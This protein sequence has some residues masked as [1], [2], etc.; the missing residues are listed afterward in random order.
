MADLLEQGVAWLQDQRTKHATR[1][2]TYVR[3]EQSVELAATIGRTIFRLT[4]DCGA[5]V[6]DVTRD[7]LV[8]A[9]D[10]ALGGQPITPQRGDRVREVDAG[11][12]QTFE[13]EVLSPGGE[14]E[15]RWSDPYRRTLR[16]H[17]KQAAPTT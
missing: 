4:D 10:L 17:T 7:F 9:A 8:A 2:V 12:G 3:G 13:H 16:I 5:A 6:H 11:T 14:P 1:T 15:W